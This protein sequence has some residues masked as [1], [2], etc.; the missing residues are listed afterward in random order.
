MKNRGFTLIEL[1]VVL[2][3]AA[4]LTL[5]AVP[6]FT[7]LL[8]RNETASAASELMSSLYLAQN[9]A[10]RTGHGIVVC[11]SSNGNTCSGSTDWSNGWIV[12]DTGAPP[13]YSTATPTGTLLRVQQPPYGTRIVSSLPSSLL[14]TS[15]SSAYL[16]ANSAAGATITLC[17]T[18]D[19]AEARQV[20][21]SSVM[22]AVNTPAAQPL[23]ACP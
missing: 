6:S 22:W 21:V 23:A 11:A 4:I 10:T 3:V 2:A 8:A 15:Y 19:P 18:L 16:A 13:V 7:A 5:V 12:L 14:F 20:S 17:S 1:M 9:E